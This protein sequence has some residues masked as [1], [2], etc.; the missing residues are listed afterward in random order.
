M[1]CLTIL[2]L[3][4][5]LFVPVFG[6]SYNALPSMRYMLVYLDVKFLTVKSNFDVYHF[7]VLQNSCPNLY[8]E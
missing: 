7:I 5:I 6:I 1:I 8:S 3:V 2:L 4:D